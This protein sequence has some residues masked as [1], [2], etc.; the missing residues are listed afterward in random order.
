MT[1]YRKYVFQTECLP[2]VLHN[3]CF[4][5][6]LLLHCAIHM[7]Y[8]EKGKKMLIIEL[9]GVLCTYCCSLVCPLGISI[10]SPEANVRLMYMQI[11]C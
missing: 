9:N 7:V 8:K 2:S 10:C 4:P 3:A 11:K 1:R 5:L 6:C